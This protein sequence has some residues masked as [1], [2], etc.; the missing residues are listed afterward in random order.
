MV[1]PIERPLNICCENEAAILFSNNNESSISSRHMDIKFYVGKERTLRYL[2]ALN[3]TCSHDN[4]AEPLTRRPA[5][6]LYS[7]Q[8][9]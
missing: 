2:M 8:C 4:L 5:P 6:A 1:D 7:V 3:L 9:P